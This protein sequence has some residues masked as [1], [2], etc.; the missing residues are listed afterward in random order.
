M[1]IPLLP[2]LLVICL[3][4]LA[5]VAVVAKNAASGAKADCYFLRDSLFTPAERSFYGVLESLSFEGVTIA[6][7]VRLADF[8]GVKK[9]LGASERQASL[10]R[11]LAKHVDFLLLRQSDARP[12]LAIELDDKSH[13]Q[14]NRRV[15]DAFVDGVFAKVDL[16]VVHFSARTSYDPKEIHRV[17]D[18]AM[19]KNA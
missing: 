4:I 13:Q 16:P 17:I 12:I 18:E 15:R 7:K 14:E 2:L 19:S 9:G 8:L 11:V 6:C 3:I 1:H 5:I 10:N